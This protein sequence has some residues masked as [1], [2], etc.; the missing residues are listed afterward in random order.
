MSQENVDA[1]RAIYEEWGR[2]NF[3]TG[4]D[5]YDPLCV[6]IPFVEFPAADYYLGPQGVRKFMLE[7]LGA[8]TELTIAAEEFIEASNSVVVAAHWT[9]AGRESGA[10]TENRVFDTWTFRGRTAIRFEGFTSRAEALAA[11]GLSE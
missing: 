10:P 2:G 6:F 11:V 7:F 8:W 9:G 1:L 3:R 4:V 5:L